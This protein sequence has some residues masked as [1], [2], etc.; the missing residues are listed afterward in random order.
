MGLLKAPQRKAC[1]VIEGLWA[2]MGHRSSRQWCAGWWH[3]S[4]GVLP[5]NL[6]EL[7]NHLLWALP[8]DGP[9]GWT[10]EGHSACPTGSRS[11]GWGWG[12]TTPVN[13]GTKETDESYQSMNSMQQ[14]NRKRQGSCRLYKSEKAAERRKHLI[15]FLEN[16]DFLNQRCKCLKG[17]GC[18]KM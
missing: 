5:H 15:W 7:S 12:H 16:E 8:W 9:R 14:G 13:Y 11:L 17:G 6:T 4:H 18:G 1:L 3:L 2:W 10:H